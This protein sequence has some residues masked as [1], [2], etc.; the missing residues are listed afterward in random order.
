MVL[1]FFFALMMFIHIVRTWSSEN[2]STSKKINEIVYTLL[3]LAF[4]IYY[5]FLLLKFGSNKKG[6]F[7]PN[8]LEEL[9]LL[10]NIFIVGVMLCV[11]G[12]AISAKIRP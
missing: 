1:F 7:L 9:T 5:P 10:G 2:K 8:I 4:G 6:I 12:W 11:F 3:T